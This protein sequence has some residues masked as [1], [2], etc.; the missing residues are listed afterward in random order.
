MTYDRIR[1]TVTAVLSRPQEIWRRKATWKGKPRY[2]PE[3]E[4]TFPRRDKGDR[5]RKAVT[6]RTTVIGTTAASERLSAVNTRL[7][8][9]FATKFKPDVEAD[10]LAQY[11]ENK[12]SR[13][14]LCTKL[15][16]NPRQASFQ[17]KV[18]CEK[19][20]EVYGPE[21]WPKGIFVRRFRPTQRGYA[22][23][24]SQ[25]RHQGNN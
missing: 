24:G 10:E 1:L 23:G 17:V 5:R 3:G 16:S 6:A 7:V 20:E 8:Q 18:E 21:L 22:G 12:L 14:V 25:W 4:D 13:K 15:G 11:L 9:V 19:V 2:I